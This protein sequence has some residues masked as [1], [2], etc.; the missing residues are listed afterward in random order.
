MP[1]RLKRIG[2]GAVVLLLAGCGL[3]QPAGPVSAPSLG[4]FLTACVLA[5][6]LTGE[7]AAFPYP[8]ADEQDRRLLADAAAAALVQSA[9]R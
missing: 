5:G 1:L 3:G 2:L 8:H 4:A 7:L 9:D 6:R